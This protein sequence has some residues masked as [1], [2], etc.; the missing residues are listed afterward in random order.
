MSTKAPI[1]L[2]PEQQVPPAFRTRVE[3]FLISLLLLFLELACIRWFPAHVLYLTFFTNTIL[4]TSFLGMSLGCLAARRA[5]NFILDTPVLLMIAM[6]AALG[7]QLLRFPLQEL[8]KIGNQA[9]PQVVFFG[10]EYGS[11]NP[12]HIFIP[13]EMV[14][15][16]FFFMLALVLAG[17]GQELGRALDRLPNRVTAYSL[18]IAGSLDGITLFAACSWLE[19]PPFWWFLV[20]ALGLGYFLFFSRCVPRSRMPWSRLVFLAGVL[21]L[22]CLTSGSHKEHG[23]RVSEH[24]WSP[25]YRIDYDFLN[26]YIEV[27]LIGHQTMVS[28]DAGFPVALAYPLPYLFERDTGGKPFADMLVIGAGSGNDVSRALQWGARHVDAVEIDPVILRLGKRDHP[29]QP[30]QDPRVTTYSDDGR[31]FL[32][33]TEGQYDLVIYALVDSLVLHSSYSDIRLESFLFTQEALSDVRRH[34]A[35]G[36]VF[37]MYNYF[38]QGWIVARFFKQIQENFSTGHLVFTMPYRYTV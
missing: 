22:A 38:R 20:I 26:R 23:R 32:R 3:L 34:L 11:A 35:P 14:E 19:L 36:G 10:T 16:F 29:D 15:G 6:A 37:V 1:V 33:S 31:N 30:Y 24:L 25:Y 9:S 7:M 5:Q 12:S 21:V 17:P 4:L 2:E 27:N 8:L 13:I 18:N 28:R